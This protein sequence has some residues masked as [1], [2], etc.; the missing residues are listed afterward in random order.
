MSS[1][2]PSLDSLARGNLYYPLDIAC[3]IWLSRQ[4]RELQDEDFFVKTGTFLKTGTFSSR[5]VRT[6]VAGTFSQ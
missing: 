1:Q 4:E 2:F 5:E 3:K 6:H